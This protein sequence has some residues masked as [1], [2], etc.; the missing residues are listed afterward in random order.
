MPEY[1]RRTAIAI[2]SG[3]VAAAPLVLLGEAEAAATPGDVH[4]GRVVSEGGGGSLVVDR[5]GGGQCTLVAE[6]SAYITR[7][8]GGVQSSLA[9]FRPGEEIV[10]RGEIEDDRCV[11]SEVQSLY[12]G[13]RCTFQG[14][15][16]EGRARTSH[17]VL[18]V[19]GD[20]PAVDQVKALHPGDRVR[21]QVW[22]D[23]ERQAPV[24]VVVEADARA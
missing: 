17:G 22:V 24:L 21:G 20:V 11:A 3:S 14:M 18:D 13:L 9:A 12:R 7:G 8:V 19:R 15:E 4:V 23:P 5:T 6:A 10:W 1:T 16:S 2:A